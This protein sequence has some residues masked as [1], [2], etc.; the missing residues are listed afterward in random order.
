MRKLLKAYFAA[1]ISFDGL[2]YSFT[3]SVKAVMDA[4]MYQPI[5]W[6]NVRSHMQGLPSW[7]HGYFNTYDIAKLMT[8]CNYRTTDTSVLDDMYWDNLATFILSVYNKGE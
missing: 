8:E 3:P 2:D 1:S 7:Y 6:A 5:T 4:E